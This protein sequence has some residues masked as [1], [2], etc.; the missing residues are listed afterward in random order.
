[1][2]N[3]PIETVF[4]S[5]N[6][7]FVPTVATN[8]INYL[9]PIFL[10]IYITI[11]TVLSFRF[12]INL[13]VLLHRAWTNTTIPFKNSKIVL[14][15]QSVTPH[16]FLDYIFVN[17]EAYN[18]RSIPQE[19]LIHEFAHV[20]Q[21]HSWD[22]LFFEIMQILCWFNPVL[23]IYRRAL[24]LNHEF[25]A[26]QEVINNY[27]DV[28][29]YQLLLLEKVS[30]QAG[31]FIISQ[32]NY[33]I[34]KQRLIMMTTPKSFRKSLCKQLAIIPLLGISLS[35]FSTKIV[36]QEASDRVT[37]KPMEVQSTK[38]GITDKQLSEFN[39][40]VNSIKNDKGQPAFYKL[41]QAEGDKLKTLYLLMSKEQQEKQLVVLIPA[42]GP[43]PISTPTE[44]QMESWKD[45]NMY[46]VWIDGKRV[47][48]TVL[49]NY[50][51]TDYA[52]LYVS[53][54]EKN[55][56]NYG[57]HYY[58][59]NLMTFDYYADYYKKTTEGDTKYLI[60]YRMDKK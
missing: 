44:D 21:K 49:N 58:Q 7:S 20:K 52:N 17:K 43:L 6:G 11:A 29:A 51:P 45:A 59:V 55:A 26:D 60:G 53:K 38:E 33:S 22:I 28:R 35:L 34:T 25:L 12:V 16:S 1:M 18:R 54:L 9:P 24:L 4:F 8:E 56:I 31:S 39:D 15:D 27:K 36:A 30:Q 47:S 41:T 42:P 14:I 10:T 40:I 19:I 2:Q 23:F 32:F 57:K 46:G 13:K 48:N 37:P 50:I 3:I 5:E